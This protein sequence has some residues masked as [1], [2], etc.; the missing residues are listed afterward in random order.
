MAFVDRI[1]NLLVQPKSEWAKI[2][3]EPASVQSLYTGWIMILAAI[4][5]VVRIVLKLFFGVEL[6]LRVAIGTYVGALVGIALLALFVD[7]LA[8][9]FGGK[10]DYVASLKLVA[11]SVTPPAIAAIAAFVPVAG[12]LIM[13]AGGIYGFY[14]FFVGATPLR[15]SSAEKSASF[16]IVAALCAVVLIYVLYQLIVGP[17]AAPV[18]AV[19]AVNPM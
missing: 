16:T 4:G 11:F 19:P 3:A 1:R 9:S 15:K 2:A 18:I 17:G 8:P 14:L 5:P 10:R 7:I 13:I 6:E 12:R